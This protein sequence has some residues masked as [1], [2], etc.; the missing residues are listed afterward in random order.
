MTARRREL[1]D[2]PVLLPVIFVF[3]GAIYF[4]RQVAGAPDFMDELTLLGNDDGMWLLSVRDFLAGQ[5]WFDMRQYRVLPPDGLS[6]HWSRLVSAAQAGMVTGFE[7]AVGREQAERLLSLVWPMVLYLIFAWVTLRV[8]LRGFG[9]PAAVI[10]LISLWFFQSYHGRYFPLGRLDHHGLQLILMLA[11]FGQLLTHGA[12]AGA[13]AGVLSA[14]SLAIGLEGLPFLMLAGVVFL[15]RYVDRKDMAFV[16]FSLGLGISAPIF[17][18]LQTPLDQWGQVYCDQLSKP[19]LELSTGA[20]V[21]GIAVLLARRR[22]Q[23][24]TSRALLVGAVLMVLAF[25]LMP[26]LSPCFGGPFSDVPQEVRTLISSMI[27]ESQSAWIIMQQSPEIAFVF[28]APLGL[29]TGLA[30]LVWVLKGRA[31]QPRRQWGMLVLFLAMGCLGA[32]LQLRAI[33]WG[34]AVMAVGFG[35]VFGALINR[36]WPVYRAVKAMVITVLFALIFVPQLGPLG[37]RLINAPAHPKE[38]PQP[39]TRGAVPDRACTPPALLAHLNAL[40]AATVVT[41]MNLG[42]AVLLHSHHSVTAAPYHRSTQAMLNGVVPFAS[43]IDALDRVIDQTNADLVL[44]CGGETYGT[45]GSV[46]SLLAMGQ[47]PAWLIPVA[48]VPRP[49]MLFRVNK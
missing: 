34:H 22:L 25:V 21:L 27:A 9:V 7:W 13:L 40:P 45:P 35:A 15:L 1:F 19:Y 8:T 38:Q 32:F 6:L 16:G 48:Q 23:S 10:A 29:V 46:G 42:T 47:A 17:F 12:R 24:V 31:D 33:I 3:V 20:A 14:A 4:M 2:R 44:V 18:V 30:A 39:E 37:L 11:V 43:D 5:D 36:P 28:L 41:P 49:L 26:R